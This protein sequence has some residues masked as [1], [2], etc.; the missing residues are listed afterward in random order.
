[1]ALLVTLAG[2]IVRRS[3]RLI[4]AYFHP[5]T[6]MVNMNRL[7]NMSYSDALTIYDLCHPLNQFYDV[8]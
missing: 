8:Y 6:E 7:R 4:C 1:M 5:D 2:G 3:R